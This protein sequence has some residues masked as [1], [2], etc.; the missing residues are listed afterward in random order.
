M[1]EKC[2]LYI[3]C[4]TNDHV[5][6]VHARMHVPN[7]HTLLN[8]LVEKH[9]YYYR[10]SVGSIYLSIYLACGCVVCVRWEHCYRPFKAQRQN[11][12]WIHVC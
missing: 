9:G 1:H 6:S 11:C 2:C 10:D 3:A 12:T 4:L 5:W 7:S 8:K